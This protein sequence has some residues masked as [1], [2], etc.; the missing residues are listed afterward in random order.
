VRRLIALITA[1]MFLELVFFGVLSP[2]LPGLKH[3]FGL[4]TSQAGLLVAAYA[5]GA[6]V[7]ALPAVMLSGR[8]GVRSAALASL[9]AFAATSVAF[10]LATS[11]AGLLASRFAQGFAGAACFTAAMV[12]LLE[13]AP[14][15]RRGVLIGIAF[16]LMAT[17]IAAV[18]GSTSLAARGLAIRLDAGDYALLLAGS[19]AGAGLWA[20][21]GVGL[22]A[23]VR[24]QVP[25]VVGICTWLLFV[26]GLLFGDIGLSNVG[27]FLPGSLARAATGQ[28][29]LMLLAPSLA[30]PLL[31]L[32]AAAAAAAG[33]AATTR[34]DV[35]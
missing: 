20:A 33:W 7:G 25:A 22:G 24:N 10:G 26:E 9:L 5:V 30:V 31:A 35:A 1:L 19:A 32:Y 18:V 15:N 27:R 8:A 21:I 11:Y 29:P 2:M 12:W 17:A 16:G 6:I 28:D 34:R 13:V 14:I 3:D 4:S 23:V